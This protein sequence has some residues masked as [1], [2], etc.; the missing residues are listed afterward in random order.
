MRKLQLRAALLAREHAP[1]LRNEAPFETKDRYLVDDNAFPR[2]S[3]TAKVAGVH[4]GRYVPAN[5]FITF[6]DYVFDGLGPIRECSAGTLDNLAD[7]RMALEFPPG[8]EMGHKVR[9]INLGN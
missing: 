2:R 6:D 9:R 4:A 5:S 8:G 1:L 7:A 3:L